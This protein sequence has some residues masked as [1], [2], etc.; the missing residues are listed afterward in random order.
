MQDHADALTAAKIAKRLVNKTVRIITKGNE[1]TTFVSPTFT[2]LD[3]EGSR[4]GHST[5][6]VTDA[7]NA[8]L[9]KEKIDAKVEVKR[10][11]SGKFGDNDGVNT[12]QLKEVEGVEIS[13]KD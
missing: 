3:R 4:K 5:N 10:D 11:F 7:L 13:S 2:E 1:G 6:P 8:E 12:I 9:K